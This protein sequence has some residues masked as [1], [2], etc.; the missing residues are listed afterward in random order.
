[1]IKELVFMAPTQIKEELS[2]AN[3]YDLTVV[4][5]YAKA[6]KLAGYDV[7]VP[8]IWNVN[9]KP[10]VQLAQS[11]GID[12]RAES[13]SEFVTDLIRNA[14]EKLREHYLAFDFSVRD[15][16][17]AMQL[18]ELLSS[19]YADTVRRGTID[20]NECPKCK[21]IYG[22]DPSISQC[23]VC[24][25]P[26]EFRKQETL[27]KHVDCEELEE[28]MNLISFFPNFL[29]AKLMD[30]IENLPE[31]YDLVLEKKRDYTISYQGKPLDPRF[32]SVMTPAV[33]NNMPLANYDLRTVIHGDVVKKFDYYALA[34]MD[35]S[36]MPNRIVAHSLLLNGERKKLRWRSS[37]GQNNLFDGIKNKEL[38]AFF[39][40][41]NLTHDVVLDP[42]KIKENLKGLVRIYV[43]MN[44]ILERRN[45]G[46]DTTEDDA[47]LNILLNNFHCSVERL[48]LADAFENMRKY[49]EKSWKIVKDKKLSPVQHRVIQNFKQLYFGE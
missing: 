12:T 28:K 10:I 36:D 21:N 38:R 31:S 48:K 22:T 6:R 42:E 34:Y 30:F 39:L 4:D 2:I 23:K 32:V 18:E 8:F 15:D 13:I 20:I 29:K 7:T 26:T 37:E 25:A 27:F 9:G 47:S 19:K 33:I 5:F 44:K 49:V 45:L 41:H 35:R 46:T 3:I 11:K 17:I 14:E 43:M 16:E 24:N 1:M 40:K